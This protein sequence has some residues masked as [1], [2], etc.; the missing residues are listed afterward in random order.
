MQKCTITLDLTVELVFEHSYN[1]CE[2]GIGSRINGKLTPDLV[3][4]HSFTKAFIL[5]LFQYHILLK[6]MH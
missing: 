3:L 5:D 2:K 6:C 4:L 1:T